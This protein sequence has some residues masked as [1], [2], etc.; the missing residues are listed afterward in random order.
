MLPA[1]GSGAGQAIEVSA[2]VDVSS[3]SALTDM[4]VQDAYILGRLLAQH[5]I[6]KKSIQRVLEIYDTVR[7]PVAL[8]VRPL[9]PLLRAR[10]DS[11]E[12]HVH[13][14]RRLRYDLVRLV[15]EAARV[16]E[17]DGVE[18]A[19]AD[20]ALVAARIIRAAVRTCAFDE[21]VCKESGCYW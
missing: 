18:R 12:A 4:T 2:H 7:R 17:L 8:L 21:A 16:D 19:A 3:D 15:D 10:L 6:T 14:P 13:V 11:V 5:I 9:D 1:L 20:V